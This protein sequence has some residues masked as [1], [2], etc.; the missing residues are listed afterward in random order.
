MA[1][2][3]RTAGIIARA[4][5]MR[6]RRP[7]KVVHPPPASGPRHAKHPRMSTTPFA[8]G[9]SAV[10]LGLT[11][12]LSAEVPA[13][14]STLPAAPVDQS[15]AQRVTDEARMREINA[16]LDD[17]TPLTPSQQT[18]IIRSAMEL[19]REHYAAEVL[20]RM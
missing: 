12:F 4:T 9:A 20:R 8:L 2:R 15:R 5:G 17:A 18:S 3:Q 14:T 1:S 13:A 11:L 10:C 16:I 19:E 6:T 7:A